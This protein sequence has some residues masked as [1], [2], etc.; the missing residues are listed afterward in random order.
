MGKLCFREVCLGSCG[1][2]G[3][4]V[5]VVS[6]AEYKKM[7]SN[8]IHNFDKEFVDMIVRDG[9]DLKK[10]C[11]QLLNGVETDVASGIIKGILNGIV[12]VKKSIGQLRGGLI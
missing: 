5:K 4:C 9:E 7:M 2:R 12:D 10:Q 11:R 6:D 1:S 3:D 8:E